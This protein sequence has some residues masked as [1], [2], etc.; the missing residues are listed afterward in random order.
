MDAQA[1]DALSEPVRG[2]LI[3][4]M[5]DPD[6]HDDPSTD[7]SDDPS[8]TVLVGGVDVRLSDALHQTAHPDLLRPG[9]DCPGGPQTT[10]VR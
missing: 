2:G 1:R 10:L 6:E 4:I 3:V 9:H 5:G 8:H 7:P